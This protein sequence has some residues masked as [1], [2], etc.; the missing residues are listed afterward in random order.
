MS[1][2]RASPRAREATSPPVIGKAG[3][4]TVFLTPPATPKPSEARRSPV[5]S[6]G[7][8]PSS[9]PRKVAPLLPK[10]PPSPPPPP[11]PPLPPPPVQ[12]PPL[13][14]EK[15]RIRSS[16]SAF[17]FFWDAIAKVQDVHS[18][19]DEY[20][21]NVLG[22]DQSKYQWAL[23]EYYE[24]KGVCTK[25]HSNGALVAVKALTASSDKRIEEQFMVG[26]ST[27]RRIHHFDVVK[28]FGF[29]YESDSIVYEFLRQ[30]IIR[31]SVRRSY[32][33][34]DSYRHHRP[35]Q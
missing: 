15:P 16:G 24:N 19:L 29:C 33:L 11:L 1:T 20:L 28:L 4:Y 31:H 13:N 25:D 17:G 27:I 35:F 7:S 34:W 5:P 21:A 23:N 3:S 9:S 6:P 10:S 14:F 32:N 8:N 22:L 2:A 12:V 26:V 18:S 30:A